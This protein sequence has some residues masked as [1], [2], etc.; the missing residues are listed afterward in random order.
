MSLV[1]NF[2]WLPKVGAPD[3]FLCRKS[4]FSPKNYFLQNHPNGQELTFSPTVR[5]KLVL[6]FHDGGAV[7]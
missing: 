1:P 7:L 2:F 5:W 4:N 6:S 3:I